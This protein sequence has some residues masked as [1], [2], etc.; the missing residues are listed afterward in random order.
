MLSQIAKSF[1][2]V[3][4]VKSQ[5]IDER[6]ETTCAQIGRLAEPGRYM[7]TFG[8]LTITAEDLAVWEKFPNAA[9][10]LCGRGRRPEKK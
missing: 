2:R 9:F 8:W 6:Q 3:R 7:F 1:I 5:K 4:L 10:T